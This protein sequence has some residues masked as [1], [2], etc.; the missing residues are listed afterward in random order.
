MMHGPPQQY[1]SEPKLEL[2]YSEALNNHGV[3]PA[4]GP[5]GLSTHRLGP[6]RG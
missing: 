1:C 4:D 5:T 6:A 3:N 2:Q